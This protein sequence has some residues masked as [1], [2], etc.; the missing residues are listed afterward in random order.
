MS[1]INTD[2]SQQ[3]IKTFQGASGFCFIRTKGETLG[4]QAVNLCNSMIFSIDL[5]IF[6][7]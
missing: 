3:L 2:F 6:S 5:R 7:G 4:L 1:G